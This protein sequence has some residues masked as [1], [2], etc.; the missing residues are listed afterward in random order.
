MFSKLNSCCNDSGFDVPAFF[1]VHGI[2][3]DNA[4]LNRE[5]LIAHFLNGQCASS[6]APGCSEVA[7]SIRSPIKIAL[8]ITEAIVT[9]CERKEIM[10]SDL[11]E[12]CSAIGVTTTQR[13]EYTIL[14]QRLRTRCNALRPLLKCDGLETVFCGIETLGKQSVQHLSSQ[15][16]LNT[17]SNKDVDST[18][19][20]V[21]DHIVSGECQ[22]STSSLCNSIED[23]YQSSN[24]GA[25]GDLETYILQ[26][27]AAKKTKLSKKVLQRVLKSR[28]VEFDESDNVGELRRHLRSH[29]TRLRKGKKS[30][31]S[32]NQR[33]EAESKH[34]C[35]LNEIRE[36]WPQPVSMGLKEECIH[37]FRVAT[38]SESLR[39][40]TCACC[41]ESTN[42]SDRRVRRLEEIDLKLM[43]DRTNLI[44]K[45]GCT[46]PEP[47]FKEG[48]LANLMIDVNG[49][50]PESDE[51]GLSL[52]LCT[53]CDSSL[54]K[55][56]LPRLAIANLN[57]LGSVPPEM[58]DMTMAEEMLIARCR[59]K[60][61]IV[62]LQ[63]NHV[64]VSLPSS[65]RGIKGNII[66][67]PQK[68]GGL[69]DILPPPVD[70]VVHL[71]CILFVGQ[72]LPSQLWLK[73][74]AYPLVVRREVVR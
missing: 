21:V 35:R 43:R 23:E 53:R 65:Q 60:C 13:P 41:A 56:K 26:L 39:Q 50:S 47:P 37:N 25:N 59:A 22:A 74:K 30:E 64:S 34:H 49:I 62:K 9:R 27:A 42:C 48:P 24:A 33:A 71:I 68:V 44:F 29:I 7:R 36:E 69:A 45:E 72:T 16:K 14:T 20:A 61:C 52:Q 17:C 3:F 1:A 11:L 67:Y 63:D 58:T 40:F 70:D 54:Q 18:R 10:P 4:Q 73:D 15:H 19:T 55:G 2:E 32:H 51:N 57:V 46:P 8:M 6:K 5:D 31:W 28:S 38:S 12:Y 66:I